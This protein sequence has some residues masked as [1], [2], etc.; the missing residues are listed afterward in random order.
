M[1]PLRDNDPEDWSSLARY[2]PHALGKRSPA[3]CALM[4]RLLEVVERLAWHQ[5]NHIKALDKAT[6]AQWEIFPCVLKC[7]VDEVV[8]VCRHRK[9]AT[10]AAKK[11]MMGLATDRASAE[12]RSL[13]RRTIKASKFEP[14]VVVSRPRDSSID[15][16]TQT[17]A[18]GS[19]TP[20]PVTA[21]LANRAVS[22][23]TN[24][25][26]QIMSRQMAAAQANLPCPACVRRRS[27]TRRLSRSVGTSS[28][29]AARSV[30]IVAVARVEERATTTPPGPHLRSAAMQTEEERDLT[31]LHSGFGDEHDAGLRPQEKPTRRFTLQYSVSSSL[32]RVYTTASENRVPRPGTA[33]I[34]GRQETP[35]N[36]TEF[37]NSASSTVRAPRDSFRPTDDRLQQPDEMTS[38]KEPECYLSE[39]VAEDSHLQLLDDDSYY[40]KSRDISETIALPKDP[41]EALISEESKRSPRDA[42]EETKDY[43]PVSSSVGTLHEDTENKIGPVVP[44]RRRS[45]HLEA[46]SVRL[47]DPSLPPCTGAVSADR[48]SDVSSWHEGVDDAEGMNEESMEKYAKMV[49]SWV[50]GLWG[51]SPAAR[52]RRS[53]QR[54]ASAQ[55]NQDKR[56]GEESDSPA[57]TRVTSAVSRYLA[58]VKE[59]RSESS[60]MGAYIQ[61]PI[62]LPNSVSSLH[63][64]RLGK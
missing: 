55:A 22:R 46:H 9:T 33:D 56:R 29:L 1:S 8:V 38:S 10:E 28:V 60:E 7:I 43:A 12:S 45:S 32:D 11:A 24:T 6:A 30:G 26:K 35:E 27:A 59:Q 18:A 25:S 16:G 57:V 44:R 50:S 20:S 36:S 40:E 21:E 34:A 52:R 15:F 54:K 62:V 48:A 47:T 5:L 64:K 14:K 53:Y 39:G 37:A 19:E 4:L 51:D 3:L 49:T 63:R 17:N 23:A 61:E 2:I 42:I 41:T 58:S 13:S 31:R